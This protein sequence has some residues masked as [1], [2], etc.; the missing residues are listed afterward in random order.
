[1]NFK[2]FYELSPIYVYK[3]L[4][5]RFGSVKF[6]RRKGSER[7][8]PAVSIGYGAIRIVVRSVTMPAYDCIGGHFGS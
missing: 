8:C 7:F 2:H 6:Y 4:E 5:L 3:R 1:M